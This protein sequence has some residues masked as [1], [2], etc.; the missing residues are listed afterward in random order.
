MKCGVDPQCLGSDPGQSSDMTTMLQAHNA[1]RALHGTPA[2]TWSSSLA[3]GAQDWASACTPNPQNPDRFAHSGF[4]NGY[5]ENLFWG[6][7]ASAQQ[8]A[9]WWYAEGKRYKYDKPIESDD[10]GD[11]DSS[12]EVRHFTQLVWRDTTE[13]G[14]GANTCGARQFWVC[15]YQKQGNYNAHDAG[16]LEANVPP[17]GGG[18][19]IQSAG[20]G[21]PSGGVKP[22]STT[23]GG[24]GGWGSPDPL[25][26]PVRRAL[27]GASDLTATRYA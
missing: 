6:T 1:Y 21:A 20:G 16:V 11:T 9:D 10:A 19:P 15:R 12:K 18:K 3:K 5:G 17:V 24:G 26:R 4:D 2:L 23:P 25:R 14:C 22:Q 13:L 27:S 8:A 7:R